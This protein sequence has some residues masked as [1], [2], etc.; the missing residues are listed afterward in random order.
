[1]AHTVR[2]ENDLSARAAGDDKFKT[3]FIADEKNWIRDDDDRAEREGTEV[4]MTQQELV[5]FTT[6]FF[7]RLC[8]VL[9]VVAPSKKE[10]CEIY[11]QE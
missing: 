6:S 10:G 4:E 1:M 9:L 11:Q 8:D 5:N 3:L 7:L 2:F